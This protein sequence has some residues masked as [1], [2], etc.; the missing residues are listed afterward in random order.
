MHQG[1]QGQE[2]NGTGCWIRFVIV[3]NGIREYKTY[4]INDDME[5]GWTMQAVLFRTSQ[6]NNKEELVDKTIKKARGIFHIEIT[7]ETEIQGKEEL[8]HKVERDIRD[9]SKLN[10]E[11][12]LEL[13]E[14]AWS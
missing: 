3:G 4:T 9:F 12:A 2:W 7:E 10:L 11:E 6:W 5:I 1:G 13:I 8:E 14:Y